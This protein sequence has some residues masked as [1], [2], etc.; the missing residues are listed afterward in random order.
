MP[1]WLVK[2]QAKA[3]AA[4]MTCTSHPVTTYMDVEANIW[5]TSAEDAEEDRLSED[6]KADMAELHISIPTLTLKEEAQQATAIAAADADSH[7]DADSRRPD[8][9]GVTGAAKPIILTRELTEEERTAK[10]RGKLA[11]AAGSSNMFVS[12]QMVG[13]GAALRIARTQH[14]ADNAGHAAS[15]SGQQAQRLQ[16]KPKASASFCVKHL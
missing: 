13:S 15:N 1:A 9:D 14:T 7:D 8:A 3:D 2:P 10:S 11:K 12:N 4:N 5:Y 6:E 16:Q